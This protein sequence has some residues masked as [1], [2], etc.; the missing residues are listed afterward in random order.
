MSCLHSL[1]LFLFPGQFFLIL[2]T[3]MTCWVSGQGGTEFSQSPTVRKSSHTIPASPTFQV[4]WMLWDVIGCKVT[5]IGGPS[6]AAE[7]QTQNSTLRMFRSSSPG[8]PLALG[9]LSQLPPRLQPLPTIPTTHSRS[10][11]QHL[12]PRC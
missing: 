1:Q 2:V 9:E 8:I 10:P 4:T 7:T 3:P 6:G 12:L 11:E 5:S